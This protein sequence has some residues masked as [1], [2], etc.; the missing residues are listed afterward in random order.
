MLSELPRAIL[1]IGLP[2]AVLSW[3]L[4]YRLYSRGELARDTN[5]KA[6]GASLKSIR[7]SEKESRQ[8]SDSL[9]HAKWMKFGGG[10][11]GVAAAWTLIYIEASGVIG[12]IA[13][14]STAQDMFRNGIGGFITQQITGQVNTF[15]DAATW[16]NWWPGR[17]HNPIVWFGVAYLA[18]IAGLELA[19]FETRIG[20]RVVELDSRERWLSM[21]PFRK[22]RANAAE[23]KAT[24]ASKADGD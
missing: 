16:F 23:E 18:Y 5:R 20:S 8:T 24:Q 22:A 2:V 12:V 19:R 4:F 9:L 17:G 13:H 3:L 6:I 14:P 10:F 7:K 11:Y 15:V 1:E 21:T